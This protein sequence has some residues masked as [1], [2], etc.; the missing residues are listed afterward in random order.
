MSILPLDV[1]TP[2]SLPVRPARRAALAHIPG[3][4][5]WPI[6]GRTLDILADPKGEVERMA[7]TYGLVYRTR[8][9]GETGVS[10]LGPDANSFVLLDQTKLFSSTHGWGILLDRL[11]PRGL[12]LLDFEEHRMHRRALSAAFK[13]ESMRSYLT[14]LDAGIA[15]QIGC[16]RNRPG[17]TL[18]YPAIK[19]LTFDLA[20]TSFFG[21]DDDPRMIDVKHAIGEMLAASVT[22]VRTPWP[23][24]Q[25]ARGLKARTRLNAYLSEQIP[26]RRSRGGDDLFSQLCRTTDENDAPLSTQDIINH[27]NFLMMA[28][29]DTLASSLTSLVYFLAANPQWQTI[30]R[31]EV[32]SMGLRTDQAIPYDKLAALT[33]TEMAFKEAMRIMPPVPAIA[34]RAMRS[35]AFGGYTIPAGTPI[36]LNPLYTHHMAEHWPAP[37]RFD[38]TRFTDTAQRKHH[39]HAYVPFGGGA[40]MCLGLHFAH[41]Q[42]KCFMRHFLQNLTVSLEPGYQPVWQMWP[43]PKPKDGLKVVLGEA[44]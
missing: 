3:D 21:P 4:E 17:P 40:H 34:R 32:A 43:I 41:M 11:F 44:S 10:L 42:V 38:P 14:A 27:M 37:D 12:M 8:V 23:G 1:P 18:F 2:L 24:T 25:M 19:Q 7:A 16:W 26:V 39:R 6:I 13:P 35:F 33:K 30:L 28:A 22:I 5:G 20:A 31:D 15:A 36:A 29:H 9:L